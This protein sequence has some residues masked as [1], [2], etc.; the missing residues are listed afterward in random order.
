[1]DKVFAPL[2]EN[3]AIDAVI[4]AP[5]SKSDAHRKL[6]LAALCRGESFVLCGGNFGADIEATIACLPAFGAQASVN[7]SGVVVT[8]GKIPLGDFP[9]GE[10][11]STLRFLLPVAALMGCRGTFSGK[12]RLPERPLHDLLAEL[13]RHGVT[14]SSPKLP[15]ALQGGWSGE[16]EVLL[17]GDVSSQYI[18]GFMLAFASS[19]GGRIALRGALQS[20][21]YVEM[22]I[23]ALEKFSVTVQKAQN[24]YIL[25]GKPVTP[26]TLPVEGDW[27]NGAVL[28][29]A[30]AIGGRVSVP[31]LDA[32]S[33]QLDKEIVPILQK[34]GAK[35]RCDEKG[36]VAERGVLRGAGSIDIGN[37]PDLAP[38]L[39]IVSACAAGRTTLTNAS[40]L[41]LKESDRLDAL[42]QMLTDLGVKVLCGNDFLQIDGTGSL[43]GGKVDVRG[44]HRL[45]MAAALAALRANSAVA[46][47]GME[48]VGKSWR[49]FP[50]VWQKITGE[51]K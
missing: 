20:A 39:A 21:G 26:G 9:C 36:A 38:V 44:D 6:I 31:G 17:P 15:F 1:M 3:F 22:T 46:I 7:S 37:I 13:S 48:N 23:K 51:G 29:A 2:P 11:G 30:G 4:E 47:S 50:E 32:T 18:T 34:F 45:V 5:K 12:G 27:S 43:R 24:T 28:L 8:P 33:A 40:R 19:G 14:T 10:S 16:N 49:D 25:S 42:A 41:R 35:C